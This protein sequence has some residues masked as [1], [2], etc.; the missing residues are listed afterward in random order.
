V[1]FVP[2]PSPALLP[3]SGHTPGPQC[4][5]E[6]NVELRKACFSALHSQENGPHLKMV[7]SIST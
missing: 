7:I 5:F 4:L 2:D 3:S 1:L 6:E